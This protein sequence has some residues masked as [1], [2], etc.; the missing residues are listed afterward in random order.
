MLS[1]TWGAKRQRTLLDGD[2]R[3]AGAGRRG[4]AYTMAIE[5]AASLAVACRT[6][7][8]YRYRLQALVRGV[9]LPLLRRGRSHHGLLRAGERHDGLSIGVAADHAA[10]RQPRRASTAKYWPV[11]S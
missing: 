9:V 2:P 7:T 8:A 1:H 11:V 5:S 4:R 6:V 3:T 10:T